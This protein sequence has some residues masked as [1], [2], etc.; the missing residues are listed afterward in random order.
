MVGGK[1]IN[2]YVHHFLGVP[3]AIALVYGLSGQIVSDKK[4]VAVI[5]V[6]STPSYRL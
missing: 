6:E 2:L 5:H 4:Q 1:K 3:N